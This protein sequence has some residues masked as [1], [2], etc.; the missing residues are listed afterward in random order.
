MGVL[1]HLQPLATTAT[2]TPAQPW[3]SCAAAAAAWSAP[4]RRAPPRPPRPP[5]A[6]SARCRSASTACRAS[7]RPGRAQVGAPAAYVGGWE[8]MWHA[9]SLTTALTVSCMHSDP[10]FPYTCCRFVGVKQATCRLA[11]MLCRTF[12]TTLYWLPSGRAGRLHTC[13]PLAPLHTAQSSPLVSSP[14]LFYPHSWDLPAWH[15]WPRVQALRL[16]KLLSWRRR[17]RPGPRVHCM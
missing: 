15:R 1:A 3:R 17:A 6:A 12:G 4:T 8:C 7:S 9:G 10:L 16:W 14:L 2:L 5:P 13:T 11:G